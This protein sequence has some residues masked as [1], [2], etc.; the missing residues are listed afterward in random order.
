MAPDGALRVDMQA[1]LSM[2]A[3]VLAVA[4]AQLIAEV[5]S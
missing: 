4:A 5:L 1:L 3:A 2:L